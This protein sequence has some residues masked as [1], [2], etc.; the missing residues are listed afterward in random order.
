MKSHS[1]SHVNKTYHP[2]NPFYPSLRESWEYG[3]SLGSLCSRVAALARTDYAPPRS[4]TDQWNRLSREMTH[5]TIPH[6]RDRISRIVE[7]RVRHSRS[8]SLVGDDLGMIFATIYTMDFSMRDEV[9]SLVEMWRRLS[10]L[11]DLLNAAKCDMHVKSCIS[12]SDSR[13]LA[14]SSHYRDRVSK[15]RPRI[16]RRTENDWRQTATR[17]E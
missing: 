6:G 11:D 9:F 16:A 13:P 2:P 14:N 4:W 5:Q 8:M 3:K 17:V 7:S 15:R 1:R 12:R 10:Y